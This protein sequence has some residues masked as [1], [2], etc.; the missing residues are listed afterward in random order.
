MLRLDETFSLSVEVMINAR[1][2]ERMS[3][4]QPEIF[5]DSEYDGHFIA[6]S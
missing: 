3:C 1:M 6:H 4:R 2:R 5:L